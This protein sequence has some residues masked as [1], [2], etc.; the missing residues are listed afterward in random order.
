VSSDAGP[1]DGELVRRFQRGD[2]AA[3]VTLMQRH[4]RRVYNLAYRMV[5]RVEDA[6][7]VTQDAFVS[8]YRHLRNFRGDSAFG[9]WLHRIAVNA[10]Y[11]LLRKRPTLTVPFDE[12]IGDRPSGADP[13]E[14]ASTA[15]DVQRALLSVPQEFRA[16]LVLHEVQDLPVEEIATA[17]GIPSGTVKSRLH[18]G[19]IAL[20]KAL[21]G[22]ESAVPIATA[23]AMSQEPRPAPAP[24]NPPSS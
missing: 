9:T 11:D 7:D 10:C 22:G 12:Q 18:R 3:F 4:E 5:G 16:V 21:I 1:P 23:G 24:S 19:R 17:L 13:A 14:R 6:R 8:A 2:E 15:A 20:G